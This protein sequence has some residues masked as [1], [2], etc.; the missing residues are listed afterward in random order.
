MSKKKTPTPV[1]V[2]SVFR[3]ARSEMVLPA[4]EKRHPDCTGHIDICC[5]ILNLPPGNAW[6]QEGTCQR[7]ACKQPIAKEKSIRIPCATGWSGSYCSLKCSGERCTPPLHTLWTT[8]KSFYNPRYDYIDADSKQFSLWSLLQ[9]EG[10]RSVPN[11]TVIEFYVGYVYDNR[12]DLE[13]TMKLSAYFEG[14]DHAWYWNDVDDRAPITSTSL[15]SSASFR[16]PNCS[17][18]RFLAF[19]V[20]ASARFW[21]A[22]CH[23][24]DSSCTVTLST[25]TQPAIRKECLHCRRLGWWCDSHSRTCVGCAT[26]FWCSFCVPEPAAMLCET[27][28]PKHRSILLHSQLA[29]D[30]VSL[31]E[32]TLFVQP[33][34]LPNTY[35]WTRVLGMR[36]I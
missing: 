27:C 29:M 11:E 7:V 1:V 4:H 36:M 28:R 20:Y 6:Y 2:N 15:M 3:R 22:Y 32:K 34:N 8:H 17:D 25:P 26:G 9:T 23:C 31:L 35:E 13:S 30:L 33:N 16:S 10:K 12:H 24:G 18:H 14:P 19:R 5:C 21:G